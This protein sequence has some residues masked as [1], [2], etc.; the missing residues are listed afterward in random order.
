[1]DYEHELEQLAKR[2]QEE[3]YSVVVHP[4]GDQ[5]PPFAKDFGADILAMRG[6]ERVLVQ[7]KQDR[8]A[9][10][11][12]PN[13]PVRAGI[14]N[15]Q[16]G[17]RFDLVILNEADPLRRWTRGSR[18]PS[19]E[20]INDVLAYVERMIEGGD[21]RAACV[22]AWAALEAA[23]RQVTRNGE[24]YGRTTPAQLLRT[25]Y[26]NGILSREDFDQLNQLFRMR[27]EIVHGLVAP[28]IDPALIRVAV[29]ATHHLL[30]GQPDTQNVAS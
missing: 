14:T 16:P 18:E 21:L 11:A 25:L 1:M 29:R 12:D 19:D 4:Q 10:E 20:E 27:T 22:F 17:W 30:T 28:A 5:L 24:L 15:S 2:Y 8:T 6:G 23:M 7:V 9:L 13:V 3:G 26:G